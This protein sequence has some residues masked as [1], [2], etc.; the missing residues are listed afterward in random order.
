M[1]QDRSADSYL[2][3]NERLSATLNR[4]KMFTNIQFVFSKIYYVMTKTDRKLQPLANCSVNQ[5]L[6]CI[7]I[8]VHLSV[9]TLSHPVHIKL[10]VQFC[11]CMGQ[12]SFHHISKCF[13]Y[14]CQNDFTVVHRCPENITLHIPLQEDI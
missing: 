4:K 3:M 11:L 7:F 12:H 13:N 6:Y 1:T 5:K 10:T 9:R 2:Y 8:V 14:H